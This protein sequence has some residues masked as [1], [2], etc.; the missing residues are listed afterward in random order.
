M[1][2][3]EFLKC[4]LETA[5]PDVYKHIAAEIDES[6]VPVFTSNIQTIFIRD[7]PKKVAMHIFEV[8]LLDGEQIIFTLLLKMIEL[9]EETILKIPGHNLLVYL[10]SIMPYECL[11]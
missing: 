1:G 7:C 4:V 2:F 3:L 6:L 8:F 10:Q 11:E 9:K 5:Y